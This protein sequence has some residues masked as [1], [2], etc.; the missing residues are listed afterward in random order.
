MFFAVL[1]AGNAVVFCFSTFLFVVE[2]TKTPYSPDGQVRRD[3][4]V[5]VRSK[6]LRTC[7]VQTVYHISLNLSRI[8]YS[9]VMVAVQT[10]DS[11]RPSS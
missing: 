10:S 5:T 9:T 11:P 4:V 6:E 8:A 2:T 1:I 3:L 7:L